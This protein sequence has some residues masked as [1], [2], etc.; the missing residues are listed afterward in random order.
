MPTFE[1]LIQPQG[2]VLQDYWDSK[3]FVQIIIGPLGSGK[4]VLTCNKII[5]LMSEQRADR[6]AVRKSRWLAVRNTFSELFS[7]TIKDWLEIN[8]HLGAF[9]GGG[10]GKPPCHKIRFKL[11]DGTTVESEMMFLSFDNPM[12]V[13]KARGLQLTGVWANETKELPKSAID[14]L[15]LRVGRYPSKKEGV[16]C[17]WEG[18]IGDTNAPDTD[19][20]LYKVAEEDRPANWSFFKQPGGVVKDKEGNW[21]QNEKAEN[22]SNLPR[23]YYSRGMQGKGDD[24]ISVNLGNNY[25]FVSNG[26]PVHPRYVD[27][28]HCLDLEFTP[29][30]DVNITLGFDFGREPACAMIQKTPFGG[31]ICFDEFVG[32]GMG[33]VSFAP[34]LSKYLKE[35]YPGYKFDGYGDPS[36]TSGNQANDETPFKIL[37]ACGIPAKPT[38]KSN[39]VLHRRS[40]I[41]TPLTEMG[42]D[43]KP[44]LVI[45][46]AAQ[47]IRKGL[48]GGFCYKRV[49]VGG[50]ERYHDKPDKNR[51]SH[52][53]EAL[54]YALV[55]VGEGTSKLKRGFES[56]YDNWSVPVNG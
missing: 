34:E 53:V 48:A 8:E 14:M 39:D 54:E 51:Y 3:E 16:I 56:I 15:S 6:N 50:D 36:G 32:S 13:K 1:H 9:S 20:W 30:K 41:E 26:K 42:M 35:T 11:E 29:L 23:S 38:E 22:L 18:M 4:T 44:R 12:D 37:N 7:T 19:H 27:S 2:Q 52:P 43:G 5:Q 55:G 40:A 47:T 25:G 46:P 33:A 10:G 21:E 45:L 31:Y 24:W 28:V 49:L 17:T